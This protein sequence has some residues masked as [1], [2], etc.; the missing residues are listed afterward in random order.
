VGERQRGSG[1]RGECV[2]D[3]PHAG[4][5]E[6]HDS[7]GC[8][9]RQQERLVDEGERVRLKRLARFNGAQR[10]CR[11]GQGAASPGRYAS[12]TPRWRGEFTRAELRCVV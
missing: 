10:A 2:V 4:G 9:P 5:S 6:G 1:A 11:A 12:D 7:V 3:G 8:A